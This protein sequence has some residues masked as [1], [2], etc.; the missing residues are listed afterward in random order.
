MKRST[1]GLLTAVAVGAMM[2]AAPPARAHDYDRGNSDH[3]LRY[4]AYLV[5]PV[6][7]A[8]EYSIARPIHYLAS[9]PYWRHILGHA[10]RNE[11]SETGQD[12]VCSYCKPAPASIECPNCHKAIVKSRDVYWSWR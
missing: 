9:Q 12:L 1:V 8:L 7:M 5:N 3:P 10:P 4:V 2:S 11:R 6:G